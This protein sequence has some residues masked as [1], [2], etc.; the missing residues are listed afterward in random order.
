MES[1][2][3]WERHATKMALVCVLLVTAS[4]QGTGGVSDPSAAMYGIWSGAMYPS[5]GRSS[6]TEQTLQIT[7]LAKDQMSMT[8]NGVRMPVWAETVGSDDL[9]F[10]CGWTG[11]VYRMSGHRN[12]QESWRMAG[13]MTPFNPEDHAMQWEVENR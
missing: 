5:Q 11:H 8:L 12:D 10:L 13:A 3:A 7:I 2:R 4:C 9:E 1:Q 6:T